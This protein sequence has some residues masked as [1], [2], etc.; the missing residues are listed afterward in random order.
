MVNKTV[1]DLMIPLGDYA[2]VPTGTTVLDA[3]RI[4]R[5]TQASLPPDRQ[6]PRAVLIIDRQ[7][8]VIGQLGHLDF[9]RALEP[10]YNMLGDL[11]SLSRAGVSNEIIG[12]LID[13]LSFWQGDI[14]DAC[15]RAKSVVVDEIMHPLTETIE[16]SAPLSEAIHKIVMWQTMRI[17]VTRK[18]IVVGVLR[19][20]DLFDEAADCLDKLDA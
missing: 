6:P 3:I 10:K 1:K 11:N 7:K 15:Q 9:L 8:E 4:L 12:T 19:L 5:R 20:A 17:L 16:D 13:N 18:K 2:L 14:S